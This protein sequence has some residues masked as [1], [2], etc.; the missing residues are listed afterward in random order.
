MDI[1]S[2][3]VVRSVAGHDKG[4]LMLLLTTDSKSALVCDGRQR[5][6]EKP[7]RKNLKHIKAT[8]FTLSEEETQSNKRLRKALFRLMNSPEN[9]EA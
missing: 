9:Q 6:L 3:T 8:S 4:E 2:G 1:K 7:K 5:R